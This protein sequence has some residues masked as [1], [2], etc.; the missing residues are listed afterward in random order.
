MLSSSDQSL[1][2]ESRLT[3]PMWSISD[4]MVAPS[5]SALCRLILRSISCASAGAS[6]ILKYSLIKSSAILTRAISSLDLAFFSG[7]SATSSVTCARSQRI[8]KARSADGISIE[9]M[10]VGICCSHLRAARLQQA[11]VFPW[12]DGI[13]HT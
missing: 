6:Y 4:S 9:C 11:L 3:I 7:F 5:N 12:P 8:L 10:I 2:R 13:P 1:P